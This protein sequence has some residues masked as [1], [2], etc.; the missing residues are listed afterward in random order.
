VKSIVVEPGVR[1]IGKYA[2]SG[3]AATRASLPDSLEKI[4]ESAFHSCEKLTRIRI[5]DSVYSLGRYAFS[6][7]H[8]LKSV[9]LSDRLSYVPMQAFLRCYA[10]ESITIPDSVTS[11]DSGA[12]QDCQKRF[13]GNWGNGLSQLLEASDLNGG[14]QSA[15]HQG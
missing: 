1:S 13:A 12:F 5:P 10:L 7:C 14:K 2:F 6:N 15:A 3:C 11:L 4:G 8:E 9:A